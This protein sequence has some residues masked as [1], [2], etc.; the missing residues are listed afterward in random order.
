MFAGMKF[1][2]TRVLIVGGG[3]AGATAARSLAENGV[4]C[5]VLERDLNH[6]K[7]CGGAIPCGAFDDLDLPESLIKK[8]ISTLRVLPPRSGPFEIAFDSGYIGIVDRKE[9]DS[10]LRD[11]AQKQGAI[12]SEGEFSRFLP[13]E[14]GRMA[15]EIYQQGQRKEVRCQL[16][17]A[18][19]GVNSRVRT[20]LGM[21]PM[22]SLHTLG[23]KLPS[24][25]PVREDCCEFYFGLF[26]KGGYSWVFPGASSASAGTGSM[27]PGMLRP[28]FE[29][30]IAEKGLDVETARKNLRGYR[31]PLWEGQPLVKGQVLFAGDSAGLV[32]PFTFEGIYY[33]MKSGQLA[34]RA[35]LEGDPGLYRKFWRQ[36]FRSRFLLMKG[37]WRAFLSTERG[38]ETLIS[39]FR[40]K[41]VQQTGIKLW[42]DKTGG[43]GSL[44]S[45]INVLRKRVLF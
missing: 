23:A 44:A 17:I 7:P 45:F 3:P 39:A 4:D 16:V 30:L 42:L 43:R 21:R 12:L 36:R 6:A 38:M 8:K 29:R 40:D 13:S 37:L 26:A 20:A 31:I 2:E 33:A 27:E 22:S 41:R 5:M 25:D 32:M 9:F 10:G 1:L 18:A 19:D 28:T 11:L 35:V 24:R 34:A 15:C 14:N